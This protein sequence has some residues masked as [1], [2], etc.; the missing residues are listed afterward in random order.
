MGNI[1]LML[2]TALMI[3]LLAFFIMLTSK[4][5]IDE[6]RQIKAM[7]SLIGSFGI[8][9]GGSDMLST[10]GQSIAPSISPM[11]MIKDDLREIRDILSNQ[12]TRESVHILKGRNRN[13]LRFDAGLLFAPDGV[14]LR[15][16]M[17]AELIEIARYI[18]ARDFPV[19]IE[20]HTDDQPPQSEAFRDNWQISALRAVAVLR[21][22]TTKG[23]ID[24]ARLSAYGY[25]GSKPIVPNTSPRNRLQNHRIDLIFDYSR[26]LAKKARE[27]RWRNRTYDFK[28]FVFDVFGAKPAPAPQ[29]PE[30]AKTP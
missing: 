23:Q 26:A 24:P 1:G 4:S 29:R 18:R 2:Y 25:A 14:D 10:D 17:E 3:L 11:E 8:L 15:P 16:E 20:G 7:G 5:V 6:K 12:L 19:I 27:D 13:I 9:P 30:N 28:G 21:F 22:L